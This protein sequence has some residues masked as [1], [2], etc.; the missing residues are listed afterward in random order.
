MKKTSSP[1]WM[2][3]FMFC[4]VFLFS[5]SGEAAAEI[6]TIQSPENIRKPSTSQR[7]KQ[8]KLLLEGYQQICFSFAGKKYNAVILLKKKYGGKAEVIGCART[9]FSLNE[10]IVCFFKTEKSGNVDL[11]FSGS[12]DWSYKFFSSEKH[13]ISQV[14]PVREGTFFLKSSRS[15]SSVSAS[16]QLSDGETGYMIL[17]CMIDRQEDGP[18]HFQSIADSFC[19]RNGL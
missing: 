8:Q 3:F 14:S 10:P 13:W 1:F 9:E 4:V 7:K 12:F 17:F 18:E 5:R 11:Q 6:Q 2:I 19:K 15:G 16:N